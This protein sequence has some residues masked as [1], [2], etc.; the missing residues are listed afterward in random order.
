MAR[1][2]RLTIMVEPEV[3]VEIQRL[4]KGMNMPAST[5]LNL[6]LTI[7]L[8]SSGQTFEAFGATLESLTAA[9]A[10]HDAQK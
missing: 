7:A 4:A 9:D 1:T 8:N 2:E 6:L 10:E 5:L 3:K